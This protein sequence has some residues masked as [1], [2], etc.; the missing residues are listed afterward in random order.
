MARNVSQGGGEYD[1]FY[2]KLSGQKEGEKPHFTVKTKDK[3]TDKYVEEDSTWDIS[4]ELRKIE[5]ESYK[6]KKDGKEE[7][8]Y[9]CSIHLLDKE[10]KEWYVVQMGFGWTMRGILNNIFALTQSQLSNVYISVWKHPETSKNGATVKVGG[11]NGEKMKWKYDYKEKLKP[12]VQSFEM[13]NGKIINDYTELDK[14]FQEEI[15]RYN[16]E[17]LEPYWSNSER[18]LE[19]GAVKH[20]PLEKKESIEEPAPMKT[21]PLEEVPPPSTNDLPWD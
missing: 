19:E 20:E 15:E 12:L 2:L 10:V 9:S 18:V 5:W 13:G 17:I 21:Q 11:N 4:G 16:K 1:F 3:E 8:G 7:T 6:Y 14:F